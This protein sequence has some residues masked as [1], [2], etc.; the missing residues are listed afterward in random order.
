MFRLIIFITDR[1]L[2]KQKNYAS[3]VFALTQGVERIA[4]RYFFKRGEMVR[5]GIMADIKM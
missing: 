3:N 5:Y 4:I 2:T 1:Y